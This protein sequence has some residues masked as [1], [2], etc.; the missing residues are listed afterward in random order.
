LGAGG[1]AFKSP[2]P[3]QIQRFQWLADFSN[4][5]NGMVCIPAME[6]F[7]QFIKQR[8]YLKNVSTRTVEWYREAFKWLAKF[9]LT[10]D[11]LKEFVI[12]MRQAGLQPV[13]CI[14]S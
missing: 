11:G 6:R 3:D 7:E 14:S 2:R 12:A 10:D 5:K 4:L 8:I 13:S 1:R 9:P